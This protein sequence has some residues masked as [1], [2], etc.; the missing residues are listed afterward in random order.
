MGDLAPVRFALLSGL[1]GF[2]VFSG[3]YALFVW[4]RRRA[5]CRRTAGSRSSVLLGR[6]SKVVLA[7]G[8]LAMG[9]TAAVRETVRP[10]GLLE[11]DG[12]HTVRSRDGFQ[13]A[14]LCKSGAVAAGQVLARFEAPERLA[15]IQQLQLRLEGLEAERGVLELQ[16]LDLDPELIRRY[17]NLVQDRRQLRASLDQLLPACSGII[18]ER[19]RERSLRQEEITELVNQL[20][21]CRQELAQALAEEQQHRRTLDR[22]RQLARSQAVSTETL[23]LQQTKTDVAQAEVSKLREQFDALTREREHVE[24]GLRQLD[25]VAAEQ[26]EVFKKEI[27]KVGGQSAEL[28]AAEAPL[29][30]KLDEDA[31]RANRLRQQKIQKLKLETR[32][33]RAKLGGTQGT[34]VVSAP[35]AGRVL[36][37]N[38]SPNSAPTDDPL[39]VLGPE[40]GCR[41]RLRLPSSQ[42]AALRSAGTVKLDLMEPKDERGLVKRHFVERR[43]TGR[44]RTSHELPNDSGYAVAVLD[45]QPPAEVLPLLAN[46]E[47]QS[48]RLMWRAPLVTLLPFQASAL[49]VVVGLL[50]LAVSRFV[51]VRGSGSEPVSG[52]GHNPSDS[53]DSPAP[54]FEQASRF[55][56]VPFP[57]EHTE[58]VELGAVGIMLRLLG[59]RFR[60][61]FI[62]GKL[63]PALVA[64]VEWALDRHQDR[65]TRILAEQLPESRQLVAGLE[66]LVG[67]G[68]RRLKQNG[69]GRRHAE[70]Q[71]RDRLL[72]ILR[73]LVPELLKTALVNEHADVPEG[74]VG[75]DCPDEFAAVN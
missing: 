16:P 11:G 25:A 37:R 20:D 42:I 36:Y 58:E 62:S 71:I 50:G 22:M 21:Q 6:C 12:L 31:E 72:R 26:I 60:L 38:A 69:N 23:E 39:L 15:Q 73:V 4:R 7:V 51:R 18:R 75:K 9:I 68:R 67:N 74:P 24:A 44:F 27:Q 59:D 49:A 53:I 40:E 2:A 56:A 61:M 29:A 47:V 48:A 55:G 57:A 1:I 10:A 45:C 43:F 28:D 66:S 70:L 63:D 64:T 54:H 52:G 33:C 5:A 3:S 14:Y 34:L 19:I 41:L 46:D 13:L 32:E 17:Q 8:L 65:A 30:K 35:T